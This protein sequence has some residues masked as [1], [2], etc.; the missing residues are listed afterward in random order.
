V[1][2]LANALEI[3]I[4]DD[5]R[6]AGTPDSGFGLLGMRERVAVHGGELEAGPRRGT[7]YR[8]RASLPIE[9]KT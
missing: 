4:T 5:G 1:R 2:Y 8:V 7:G 6:G 9:E 3:E